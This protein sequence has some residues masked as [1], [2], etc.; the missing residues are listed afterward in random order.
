MSISTSSRWIFWK[1]VSGRPNDWKLRAFSDSTTSPQDKKLSGCETAQGGSGSGP[2]DKRTALPDDSG[3]SRNVRG[4]LPEMA[5]QILTLGAN[6]Q[7]PATPSTN[8]FI[9][10]VGAAPFPKATRDGHQ[11]CRCAEALWQMFLTPPRRGRIRG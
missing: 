1:D 11:K 5:V 7:D 9:Q 2:D 4:Y 3:D 6:R 8:R 10:D